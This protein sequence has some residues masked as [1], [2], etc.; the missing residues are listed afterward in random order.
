MDSRPPVHDVL[1]P[2]QVAIESA[3]QGN[4]RQAPGVA[5]IEYIGMPNF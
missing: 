5:V 3:I 2:G 4:G 1:I